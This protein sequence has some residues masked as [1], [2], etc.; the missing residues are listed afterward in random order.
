MTKEERA[1]KWFREIPNAEAI[2]LEKKMAICARVARGMGIVFFMVLF[3][4]LAL[5]IIVDG[6]WF[7]LYVVNVLDR[8]QSGLPE[9]MYSKNSYKVL[10]LVGAVLC[11]PLIVLPLTLAR[12][13]KNRKVQAEALKL[14]ATT[15]YRERYQHDEAEKWQASFDVVG[16]IASDWTLDIDGREQKV[17]TLSE[18]VSQL[19]L[20]KSGVVD[21]I[22]LIP[23]KP[24]PTQEFGRLLS[25]VQVCQDGTP[26]Y[27][28][29]EIA[30]T[31]EEGQ[32]NMIYGK[33]GLSEEATKTLFQNLF[34]QASIPDLWDWE[35]VF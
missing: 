18:I 10:A 19:P 34:E 30:T 14:L 3:L 20:I 27:F 1:E 23:K 21:F 25:F 28:H 8:L 5:L 13:F 11:L 6:G 16:K 22:I 26:N 12:I 29:F 24:I 4:E 17:F 2:D 15:G 7:F 35:I 31:N 9:G 33:D 32:E